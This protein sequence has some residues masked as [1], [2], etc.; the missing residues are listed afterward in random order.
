MSVIGFS[1]LRN[2][3]S[4]VEYYSREVKEAAQNAVR[5]QAGEYYAGPARWLSLTNQMADD[6]AEIKEGEIAAA[7]A[8]H[9][10]KQFTSVDRK[11]VEHKTTAIVHDID[12]PKRKA[13]DDIT[14]SYAKGYSALIRA[15]ELA[16]EHALA[17]TLRQVSDDVIRDVLKHA[18]DIG[19]I[20]TRR[21]HG[22]KDGEKPADIMA[23]VIPHSDSRN[24]DPQQHHH[25]LVWNGS[26]RQDGSVGSLDLKNFVAHKFYLQALVNAGMAERLQKLGFA[27]IETT[28]GQWELAGVPEKLI[29]TWSSRRVEVLTGLAG[30]AGELGRRQLAE[31]KLAEKGE[32][33]EEAG[34]FLPSDNAQRKREAR[35]R[36]AKVT[37]QSK[38]KIRS[39]E[40]QNEQHLKDFAD[41]GI[42]PAQL[43]RGT[44]QAALS[45]PALEGAPAEVGID[46]LFERTSVATLRQFRTAVAEAAS[47]R[48]MS[49]AGVE[50]EV[51][52]ALTAGLVK[53]IGVTERGEPVVSTEKAI[54][55]EWAM[56]RA[57]QD[58]RGQ[59]KLT[60][61]A[62]EKAIAAIEVRERA[63]GKAGFTLADEQ[64][65]AVRWAAR[66]D[67]FAVIEGLAGTG[68]TTS[69]QAVV[70]AAQMQGMRTIGVAPM[71]SASETLWKEAKTDEYMSLQKLSADVRSGK[72]TLTA[73]DYILVDESG[74]AELGHVATLTEAAR[75]AGA[76]VLF[77]G[78]ERQF[79]PIGAG[80]PFAALGT[81]LG[82]SRLS[83][84]RRQR[85]PWQNAASRK[86]AAG[87]TDA[88]LMAYAAEGRWKFGRDRTDAMSGLVA[89]WT[90]DL[91]RTKGQGGDPATR[92]VIA[93]RH[94]DAHELN[95][96]LRQVL[97]EKGKLGK[98]EVTVRTLHRDGRNGQI[99]DLPL[100]NGDELIVWRKVPEHNL[101]NGDRITVVGFKPI[102]G[103]KDN[104]LMLTWKV[105][106][107]GVEVTAPLSSLTPPVG[108]DD[109]SRLPRVPF[110]Q[111]AYAVSMYASQGKTVDQSFVYGGTGLD[112]RSVYVSMTRHRDDAR[113]YWDREG[114]TQ[115]LVD[116]GQKPT[117]EA[118][119]D[120]IRREARRSADKYNVLDFVPDVDA[121]LK[122]GN[123]IEERSAPSATA[124]RMQAAEDNAAAT[125]QAA[126]EAKPE[127]VRAVA[128]ALPPMP[129]AAL[130]RTPR[131]S[132]QDRADRAYR[133]ATDRSRDQ[134]AAADRRALRRFDDILGALRKPGGLER[135]AQPFR[136]LAR[137]VAA[138]ASRVAAVTQWRQNWSARQTAQYLDAR[139]QEIDARPG[140]GG[141]TAT[142][143]SVR[144]QPVVPEPRSWRSAWLEETMLGR[145]S[146]AARTLP[147]P[148]STR[149]TLAGRLPPLPA[150]LAGSL[151]D[152]AL[153]ALARPPLSGDPTKAA[154][155]SVRAYADL[156]EQERRTEQSRIVAG[157]ARWAGKEPDQVVRELR[158]AME[159]PQDL[160]HEDLRA[161]VERLKALIAAKERVD[162]DL[163]Q[164]RV[165]PNAPI[166]ALDPATSPAGWSVALRRSSGSQ[167][168]FSPGPNPSLDRTIF[169]G[170]AS[171]V[172]NVLSLLHA[173]R[174]SLGVDP[175]SPAPAGSAAAQ[176]DGAIGT[177]REAV[178]EGRLS[179][180]A[181]MPA[182]PPSDPRRWNG[183]FR[184]AAAATSRMS[185]GARGGGVSG[186]QARANSVVLQS[187]SARDD[188]AHQAAAAA[189]AK[190][191][192]A[193]EA[194][195]PRTPQT[196]VVSGPK[197]S[198]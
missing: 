53:A 39:P 82:T 35:N 12:N 19:L 120:H 135:L 66:G 41:A 102:P 194:S 172:G 54:A 30:V 97:I 79:A 121:W 112:M 134:A 125:I 20:Q 110:L 132:A 27:V 179:L 17:K 14:I 177:L 93:Q 85:L 45:T 24:G 40:K 174:V 70:L 37:R 44:R 11:G 193:A 80:A 68:K 163:A 109:P 23:A 36:S 169:D 88:G 98:D 127:A 7:F 191:E 149:A 167:L 65:D 173:R 26:L 8:G 168:D 117:S 72:K 95:A 186:D 119:V 84:I 155:I 141:I 197:M 181:A 5:S 123:I 133:R 146:P 96:R 156:L 92:I 161:S 142:T 34:E 64:R 32:Q 196:R 67:Q 50:A 143:A 101:N 71:N 154:T 83:E 46:A 104:D 187:L 25:L 63:G 38:D 151:S 58:G 6:G 129:P 16:E 105:Q 157:M 55:T 147:T 159:R 60:A 118:V 139:R 3:K 153:T 138:V 42:T 171:T 140:R 131:A 122:T 148:A 137:D 77:I 15:A 195:A 48:G 99:T 4:A 81:V 190:T 130:R 152:R 43:I 108:P 76:Q 69:M 73:R 145:H 158:E 62:A 136:A 106:K 126:A 189:Q 166:Q 188:A 103:S 57:A 182:V 47:A 18:V 184:S 160:R 56:L 33:K 150:K 198:M 170:S 107:T 114:I 183:A 22:G 94:V 111:H 128:S 75:R 52:R 86:M 31:E 162:Q 115:E 180:R 28:R 89:D 74:M 144:L 51:Q 10:P 165:R 29:E 116:Q 49:V 1:K 178:T 21:G 59:G 9:A 78:D 100:R 164:G 175:S 192:Q 61:A 113:V 90:D 176:L 91:Q 2:G 124:A 185:R 87:D 13:A